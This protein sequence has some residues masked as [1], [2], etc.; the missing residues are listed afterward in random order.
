VIRGEYGRLRDEGIGAEELESNRAQ[1]KSQLIFSLEGM[2]NRMFRLARNEIY[3]GRFVPVAEIVDLIDGVTEKDIR[4]C[5]GRYFDPDALL[6]AVHGP[7]AST[8]A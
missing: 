1:L 5:S 4:D 7:A 8:T 6:I 3:Y 2:V